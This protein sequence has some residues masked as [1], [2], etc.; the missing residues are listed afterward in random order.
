MGSITVTHYTLKLLD[1]AEKQAKV[2]KTGLCQKFSRLKSA[3]LIEIGG[4]DA[5]PQRDTS[6]L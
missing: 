2:G 3:R 4:Y 6:Q 5:G 1:E